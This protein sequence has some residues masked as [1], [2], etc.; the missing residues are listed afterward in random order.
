M[1]AQQNR[2]WFLHTGGNG[3]EIVKWLALGIEI[4]RRLPFH[5]VAAGDRSDDIEKHVDAILVLQNRL[6]SAHSL[7]N[8]GGRRVIG[9]NRRNLPTI[10][11]TRHG[12]KRRAACCRIVHVKARP[13]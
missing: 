2:S 8:R 6:T 13:R 10:D 5:V 7:C 12:V 11:R 3:D 1:K 4:R 9:A